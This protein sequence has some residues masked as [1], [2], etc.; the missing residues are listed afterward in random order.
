MRIANS[1]KLKELRSLV[2][3]SAEN[4]LTCYKAWSRF[5]VAAV[6]LSTMPDVYSIGG[7]VTCSLLNAETLC[8]KYLQGLAL[9]I[10]QKVCRS[11][12]PCT[13]PFDQS[14]D[15]RKCR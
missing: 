7:K 13:V 15:N 1:G 8:S 2:S 14:F 3:P 9:N 11:C 12:T 10:G 4:D 6:L 5:A